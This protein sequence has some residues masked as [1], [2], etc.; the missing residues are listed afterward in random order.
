MRSRVP[1]HRARRHSTFPAKLLS[2]LVLL[3]LLLAGQPAA[4][5]RA[6]SSVV[7]R[8]VPGGLTTGT[9]DTWPN[10]CTLARALSLATGF[11]DQV[12]VKAGVYTPGVLQSD[13]FDILPGE[14]VYGGFAGT[15]S[16]L[17]ER[18]P[19]TNVTILSGDIDGNDTNT[20]GNHIDETTADIVGAY[21]N[22]YHVV[23]MDGTTT[24]ISSSTVLDG[25]T[26]TG[27]DTST[28]LPDS[29]DS[30]GGGLL[31]DGSG[32]SKDCSPTLKNLTFSGNRA[33]YKGGGIY[34]RAYSS[35]LSSPQLTNVTFRGN[36]S[37]FGYGGAMLNDDLGGTGQSNL[38]NVTFYGNSAGIAGGAIFN[39]GE[40]GES[41]PT[42]TNVTF[43]AN[44]ANSGMGGAMYNQAGATGTSSPVLSNVILWGDTASVSD[45]EIYND[46][47]AA[48]SIDYSVIDGGCGSISGASC[49]THNLA[50]DPKLDPSGPANNGGSTKTIA[51]L[52][53]SPA[54]DAGT[55]TGCT[56]FDQRGLG[57]PVNTTCDIG[58]YEAPTL[59]A[60][61]ICYVDASG[62]GAP[63]SGA[64][65]SDPY[66]HLQ[67]ALANTSC[68]Q[69]WVADG[70]YQ[71]GSHVADSFNV[72]AAVAVYGGFAGGEGS[73]GARNPATHV[74]VLSGDID[75]NDT[76]KDGNGVTPTAADTVGDN[77]YH[78]VKMT[79]SPTNIT[80]TTVLDGFTLT[81]GH[82]TASGYDSAGGG[83]WCNSG[84][85]GQECSPSLAR[86]VI[87]GN[88][89]GSGGGMMLSGAVSTASP[90][91][92]DVSFVANAAS[93][94]GG[95]MFNE[96]YDGLSSPQLTNVTFSNNSAAFSGGA[97]YSEGSGSGISSPK[98]NNVTFSNNSAS[99]SHGGAMYND[100]HTTASESSP[101]LFNVT[102]HGNTAV[103][104]WGGAMYNYGFE[105]SSTPALTNVILWGDSASSA[106]EV[107]NDTATPTF[108]HSVVQGSGGSAAWV[109]P[110]TDLGGN[111][112]ADPMLDPA[113]LANHGGYT[114]TLRLLS[115]SSATNAADDGACSP[116]DQRGVSRPLGAH[117]DIG[118][119][120]RGTGTFEDVPVAGK[121]WMEPWVEA[122]YAH[123][124]TSGC[125]KIPPEY[126]PESSVTRAA[127]AV[128]VLRAIEG[129][130]Y[131][132]P[133]SAHI[134]D[135]LP[136]TGKEWMEPWV[137][138]FYSRGI[139]TGCGAS[140]LR[141]CP[142]NPVTRAA[143]AVFLLRALEGS[144]Y[145][146]PPTVH[147]FSDMPVS[148]KEWMEPW[149]D[150]FYSR[151]ITTGCGAAPLIYC[152]ENS[153]TR[154][155]MAVFID[156]AYGL[157]P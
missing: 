143:M 56:A 29:L 67:M 7:Y 153:V 84:G 35:G 105:G 53:G 150:E 113:G 107:F 148:G 32:A 154:A 102:F 63:G 74:A 61:P 10:G 93:S 137:N 12:W 14:A 4:T 62:S 54:I 108:S 20:D 3:S 89:S 133:A 40:T 8:V 156:R 18:N 75:S 146:P 97:M 43:S 78:V 71:P 37:A 104:G 92:T 134:F 139:T 65:W 81:A 87:I 135:D 26:I 128:F 85:F 142:E 144:S 11:G 33:T 9:C 30:A 68:T 125:S 19:A 100:G 127:M 99:L 23:Y 1:L 27:G 82:G 6:D 44:S 103:S 76:N 77:V 80:S 106:P 120:E 88:S 22:S 25:F 69:V 130:S 140:P 64:S 48:P 86:L 121:E 72:P 155:A 34:T 46:A 55:N 116:T 126:C 58:A 109:G 145:V 112:D 124:I 24:P 57:R 90:T 152:P 101:Q 36:A 21:T 94:N 95:A 131:T 66:I 15:E 17:A 51:L 123:G 60:G 136:V 98:L 110:G 117:C 45:N 59:A 49:G 141:Y 111:V 50:T 73:L 52:A 31:C 147:N 38:T 91:L 79:G 122:F 132:P 151:G 114:Q 115:G 119:F 96:G 157:Y 13:S 70:L 16:S 138:E 47:A 41:S 2:A 39:Y 149:V 83:L 118:A 42:L 5:S 129:S 28:A